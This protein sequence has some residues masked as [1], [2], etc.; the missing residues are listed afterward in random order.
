MSTITTANDAFDLAIQPVISLFSRA[1][2]A[3]IANYHLDEELQSRIEQLAE[4]ANEG[5]L[6]EAE[7]DE[8]EGYAQANRFLAVLQA[9]TRR[10]ADFESS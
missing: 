10:L 4:K 9:T 6:T 2:A 3:Q 5:E 1:Q 8:Y 7:R